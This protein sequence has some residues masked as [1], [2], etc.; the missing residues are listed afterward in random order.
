MNI[1]LGPILT[2]AASTSKNEPLTD[3][4]MLE[5]CTK[6]D[7]SE[8]GNEGNSNLCD[9]NIGAISNEEKK[10]NDAGRKKFRL[11]QYFCFAYF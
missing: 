4:R 1:Y 2:G 6:G 10:E 9:A 11:K 7:V 5:Q 3:E 8:T